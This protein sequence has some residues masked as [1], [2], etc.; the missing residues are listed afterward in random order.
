[1][2][3]AIPFIAEPLS[4]LINKS[5]S[6]ANVHDFLKIAR[7]CPVFKN[8]D[9]SKFAN[10]RPISIL[11]SFSTI[12]EKLVYNRLQNHL[13]KN[14]ILTNNQFEFRCKHDASMA[15]IEMVDK[16]STENDNSEYSTGVF[17]DLLKSI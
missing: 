15:V 1:M 13:I 4:L 5:V 14:N 8:G 6:D 10:Y 16:I 2:K 3:L 9:A 11:P 17:I 7:V 12:F